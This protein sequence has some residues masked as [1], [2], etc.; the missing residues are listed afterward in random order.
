MWREVLRHRVEVLRE[1]FL[2][3]AD[4]L[5]T[6]Q[7]HVQVLLS[8]VVSMAEDVGL[9]TILD[10]VVAS[11]CELVGAR[12]GALGIIDDD[13]SLSHFITTGIDPEQIERIGELP[14]GH[15]VLGHLI[16]VP[17][18]LRLVDLA[19]HPMAIGFP[20]NHPPMKSFLGV[21]IRVREKVFGNLYLTEKE[22][23]AEFSDED[24][25]LCVALAAA[26]GVAIENARHLEANVR[27]SRWLEAGVQANEQIL[28]TKDDSDREILA[29]IA[30][31]ALEA[32]DSSLAVIA[33]PTANGQ[34]LSC[35]AS[36]GAQSFAAGEKFMLQP[37]ITRAL[38]AGVSAPVRNAADVFGPKTTSKLG[39]ALVVAL[40]LAG[41]G[42]GVLI[43]ARPTTATRYTQED[44]DTSTLFSSRVSL[45]VDLVQQH[46]KHESAL[47]SDD[48]DRIARDLHDR[49]IQRIFAAGL[50]L[51]SLRHAVTDE[52]TLQRVT[53]ITSELDES[54]RELRETIYSLHLPPNGMEPLSRRMLTAITTLT[55]D[56]GFEPRI[57]LIG[58][59]DDGVPEAVAEHLIAVLTEGLSNAVRHSCAREVEVSV[60]VDHEMVKLLITDDGTGFTNPDRVSGL[61]NM[62]HRATVLSGYCRVESTPGNGTSLTWT[63]PRTQPTTAGS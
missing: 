48:R 57:T 12:Y 61:A 19:T 49:V 40:N 55:V 31:C 9:E 44:A 60:E 50:S 59:L 15:G 32:S 5:L 39:P 29:M 1:E 58:P 17:E 7:E 3:T 26:A 8:A 30:G 25:A 24:E 47:L 6:T 22:G 28:A 51:Q 2:T 63:V 13:D 18:P 23:G 4:E 33:F 11:A 21:P 20:D 42:H 35:R 37:A 16:R 54:I 27:R 56:A 52:P 53:S 10:R 41:M 34:R 45:A 36:V 43:L 46:R 38:E 14:S 62:E